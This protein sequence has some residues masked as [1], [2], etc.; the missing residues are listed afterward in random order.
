LYANVVALDQPL[1]LNRLGSYIP[2]GMIYA[3]ARDVVD[4]S[5]QTSCAGG[6][7]KPGQVALRD[8]KRPRP[9]V[10]RMNMGDCLVVK[11]T[12]LVEPSLPP[13]QQGWSS[14]KQDDLQLFESAAPVIGKLWGQSATRAIGFHPAGL[15]LVTPPV[16]PPGSSSCL[17]NLG[18]DAN[19]V[20]QN[21]SSFANPG[22][23]L[24]YKFY[25]REE[26]NYLVYSNDDAQGRPPA[27]TPAS[28][29]PDFLVPSMWSLRAPNIIVARSRITI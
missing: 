29:S 22:Q 5:S 19:W 1:M 21:C 15:D 3:L 28:S 24:F 12:N 13:T 7:C 26:G 18:S 6:A 8:G 9:I 14:P 20:G 2:G 23:T 11:F 25:A 17:S 27:A 16:L 4:S 10:L